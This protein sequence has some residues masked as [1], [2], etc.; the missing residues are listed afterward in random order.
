LKGN[1]K[2]TSTSNLSTLAWRKGGQG[3][4]ESIGQKG[5]FPR[6]KGKTA[7]QRSGSKETGRASGEF[8]CFV[9]KLSVN[10]T[11]KEQGGRRFLGRRRIPERWENSFPIDGARKDSSG[12]ELKGKG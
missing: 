3:R 11:G 7:R 1:K 12:G 6:K 9:E 4:D 5:T 2:V 8:F 10:D